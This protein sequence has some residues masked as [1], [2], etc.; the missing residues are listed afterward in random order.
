MAR[1]PSSM[2]PLGTQ[3]PDFELPDVMDGKRKTLSSLKSDKATVVFFICAHC[4]Y[5]K[6][7]NRELA[8]IGA[9]YVPK[10]VSVIAISANNVQTHPQDAPGELKAQAVEFG[11]NFPY[12]YDE[13]QETARAY[14]A[15]CTPDTFVFDGD[16][17]LAYR[18][19][20]DDTRPD[21][22]LQ[23]NGTDLRAALDALLEGKSPSQNQKP[24]MG[25]NIKWRE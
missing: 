4:P 7:V 9:D 2:I 12:L 8:R 1:T 14:S 17:K 20:I 21:S 19:Q 10:G 23:A 18:G 24:S 13:P 22:G 25:C 3:A 6:H 16:M 5:V 15:A 11:F